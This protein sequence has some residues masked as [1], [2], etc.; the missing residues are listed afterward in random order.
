MRTISN[1]LRAVAWE[2]RSIFPHWNEL[3]WLLLPLKVAAACQASEQ[4]VS[5]DAEIS[6]QINNLIT[7]GC[8]LP[9]QDRVQSGRCL[10]HPRLL[11]S[12]QHESVGGLKSMAERDDSFEFLT[13]SDK[14][15]P[16][17]SSWII[18]RHHFFYPFFFAL[19]AL[20][21]RLFNRSAF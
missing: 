18:S 5:W 4:P 3:K 13:A 20:W 21:D 11:T 16:L 12:Q 10:S 19:I 14:C 8:R 6:K 17:C 2:P 15:L 9:L 1:V 7:R